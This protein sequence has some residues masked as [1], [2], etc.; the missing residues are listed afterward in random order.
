MF[1]GNL[2]VYQCVGGY[3]TELQNHAAKDM[4]RLVDAVGDAGA[5]EIKRAIFRALTRLRAASIKEFDII[6]PFETQ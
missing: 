2:V 3:C 4:G 1:C 6:A 5:A